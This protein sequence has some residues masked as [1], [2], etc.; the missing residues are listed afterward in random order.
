MVQLGYLLSQV[1]RRQRDKANAQPR[2]VRHPTSL[3]PGQNRPGR[4]APESPRPCAAGAANSG[5]HQPHGP[6]SLAHLR[7][8]KPKMHS[9]PRTARRAHLL[10]LLRRGLVVLKDLGQLQALVVCQQRAG[11]LHSATPHPSWP[12]TQVSS[13]ALVAQGTVCM[14]RGDKAVL[15]IARTL[16]AKMKPRAP[17]IAPPNMNPVAKPGPLRLSALQEAVGLDN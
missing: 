12:S 17:K 10:G 5:P 4:S 6:P 3:K 14:Q 9:G 11:D 15:Q 1:L 2:A 7:Q 13:R 8:R 16:G